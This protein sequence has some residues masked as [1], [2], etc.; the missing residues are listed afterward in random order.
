MMNKPSGRDAVL[1][2]TILIGVASVVGLSQWID[3]HRPATPATVEDE[4]LYLTGTTVRRV[5][6]GF[7]GLAAVLDAF[8]SVCR[9]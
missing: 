4:R 5:S 8:A 6:L 1:L 9:R 2:S 3:S 7:N